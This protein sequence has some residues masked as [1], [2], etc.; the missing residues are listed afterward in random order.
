MLLS[1]NT[2]RIVGLDALA[3]FAAPT[4]YALTSP[5]FVR[6]LFYESRWYLI[7]FAA[8]VLASNAYRLWWKWHSPAL[9][10]PKPRPTHL[11]LVRNDETLH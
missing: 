8:I 6:Q 5:S 2:R 1:R 10:Q 3:A 4:I 11:K 9:P 7:A